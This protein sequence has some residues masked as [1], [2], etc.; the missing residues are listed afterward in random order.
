MTEFPIGTKVNVFER[1]GF[2]TAEGKILKYEDGFVFIKCKKFVL[3][4]K[5]FNTDITFTTAGNSLS[6]YKVKQ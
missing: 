5:K 3:K 4:L 2:E 6:Q 1:D